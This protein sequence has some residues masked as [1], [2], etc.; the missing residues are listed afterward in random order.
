M[1]ETNYPRKDQ[2]EKAVGRREG[3]QGGEAVC[4]ARGK[5]RGGQAVPKN[6]GSPNSTII[7]EF[8]V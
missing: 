3:E 4:T 2:G 1:A 6:Y 7:K 5:G 8:K